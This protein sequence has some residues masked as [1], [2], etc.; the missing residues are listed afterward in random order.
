[1]RKVSKT[2]LFA[3]VVLMG[4]FMTFISKASETT[5][6]YNETYG[7]TTE[8]EEEFE[9]VDGVKHIINHGT[10]ISD[11][12]KTLKPERINHI[13]VADIK[14][15]D[16]LKVVTWAVKRDDNT[17]FTRCALLDIAKDYEKKHPGWVILAGVN[18]DQFY[19]GFG[20]GLG[21]NGTDYY[22]P[23]PYYPYI[24]DGD[25]L[26]AISPYANCNN[27][28]GFK[29]NGDDVQIVY[30]TNAR[31]IKG[32]YVYVYDANNN[33]LGTFPAK[34]LNILDTLGAN[35]TTII[36]PYASE[37]RAL[38]KLSKS[39]ANSFYV[40]ESP[41]LSYV[42]NSEDWTWKADT[43]Y[44]VNAFFG[45]GTISKIEESVS[46]NTNS[47]AIET[48]NP[49]LKALLKVGTYV[50]CQYEFD[51]GFEGIKE[52]TGFHTCHILNGEVQEVANGYNTPN[53][54]RSM[55]ACDNNGKVYFIATEK[56]TEPKDGMRAQEMNALMLQYGITNAFQVDGGGSVQSICRNED[57]VLDYA[58]RPY[59]GDYRP[60][61]TGHF[62][63]MKVETISLDITDV[64]NNNA[65]V[66]V[67]DKNNEYGQ[68]AIKLRHIEDGEE[69]LQIIDINEEVVQLNNLV[70]NT[71]YSVQVCI[72]QSDG[73]YKELYIK[74]GFTTLKDFPKIDSVSIKVQNDK[75]YRVK[76][77]IVDIDKVLQKA[78]IYV[79]GK[80]KSITVKDTQVILDYE[81]G[82]KEILNI[83]FEFDCIFNGETKTIK[84]EE[85]KLDATCDVYLE[86]IQSC[87][88]SFFDFE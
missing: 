8:S 88:D 6:V 2:L 28:A 31:S 51:D 25:N 57:G 84:V 83:Y 65:K 71:K 47:F 43:G 70:K 17:G 42:S 13:F 18:A 45:K 73:T 4:L 63:A 82:T 7:Y 66:K 80:K 3:I 44:N 78:A 59:E 9:I 22:A 72:K 87:I 75:S 46:L 41:E 86:H 11:S 24:S 53:Y 34:N 16:S 67:V 58:Q 21:T 77:N 74:N 14:N 26:F 38:V 1:M 5:Y 30:G 33:I 37:T 19:T 20:T 35:E 69:K 68:L 10:S 50:K 76:I 81:K 61:L 49:D 40:V 23:Q 29:N 39:S 27:V 36:A 60:V 56:S 48:T 64:D 55:F 32:L 15:N 12:G 85:Y 54:P 62:I 52:A 79:N